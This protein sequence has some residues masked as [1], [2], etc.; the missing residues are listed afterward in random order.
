M[1]RNMIKANEYVFTA[2]GIRCLESQ[3][4]L[5]EQELNETRYLKRIATDD[6][7]LK[8]LKLIEDSH[9]RIWNKAHAVAGE[10]GGS[11]YLFV[12]GFPTFKHLPQGINVQTLNAGIFAAIVC[13][14]DLEV[15]PNIDPYSL[16]NNIFYKGANTPGYI[17]H[18]LGDVIDCF[19]KI[20]CFSID[21]TQFSNP[22]E[23][24]ECILSLLLCENK[25]L[26]Q[27]S[28]S[29]NAIAAIK[30]LCVAQ[31]TD[32]R[33]DCVLQSL[34]ATDY[35]Y[36][37]LSTYQMFEMYYQITYINEVESKLHT[38]D[39]GKLQ[40]VIDETLSWKPNERNSLVRVL[41]NARKGSTSSLIHDMPKV[42]KAAM[43]TAIMNPEA[44]WSW[45]Y[46]LR[47][48]IVHLKKFQK[49]MDLSEDNWNTLLGGMYEALDGVYS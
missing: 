37:F 29:D 43:G 44:I 35:K 42:T 23:K 17:G 48:N 34:T 10:Y 2:L 20:Q 1:S 11:P 8:Y 36:A 31:K 27:L 14:L 4:L 13:E 30:Q 18:E 46:D 40:R 16:A 49:T 39:A 25:K 47:C 26:L 15:L 24:I 28:F 6:D 3:G 21:S 22:H 41:N 12:I 45:I 32:L 5:S 9:L 7:W 19:A 38:G 33:Y